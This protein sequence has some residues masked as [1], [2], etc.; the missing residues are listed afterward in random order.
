MRGNAFAV[1]H[2]RQMG[3]TLVCL[4]VVGLTRKGRGKTISYAIAVKASS[5]KP[6]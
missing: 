4:M 1:I 3:S 6:H 5:T 2:Q